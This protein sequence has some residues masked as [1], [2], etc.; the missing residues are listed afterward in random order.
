[1]Q[2]NPKHSAD[3]KTALSTFQQFPPLE[4]V[5]RP[6]VSTDQAAYYLNRRPQTLREWACLGRG[7]V[8]PLRVSGRLAWPTADLRRVLG[9]T[10]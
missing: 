7:E 5:N 4:Q 10:Q 3:T 2:T 8:R 6:T 1:M 9:V